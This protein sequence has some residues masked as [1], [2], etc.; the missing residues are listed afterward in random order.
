[1]IQNLIVLGDHNESIYR[2]IH[3]QESRRLYLTS[4]LCLVSTFL[5]SGC[6]DTG[7][8]ASNSQIPLSVN[9][10]GNGDTASIGTNSI[11]I[12]STSNKPNAIASASVVTGLAPLSTNLSAVDSFGGTGDLFYSWEFDDGAVA[13]G[14]TVSHTFEQPGLYEVLLQVTDADGETDTTILPIVVLPELQ[15]FVAGSGKGRTFFAQND[16]PLASLFGE[17]ALSWT[18]GDG[19]Q[20]QGDVVIHAY[21]SSGIFPVT[22]NIKIDNTQLQVGATEVAISSNGSSLIVAD[23][24]PDLVVA[25]GDFVTLDASN[26]TGPG[27]LAYQW[28][29]INDP[30]LSLTG[31]DTALLSFMAPEVSVSTMIYFQLTA[32]SGSLSEIDLV[33]V[34]VEPAGS[35]ITRTTPYYYNEACCASNTDELT[36]L[37]ASNSCKTIFLDSNTPYTFDSDIVIDRNVWITPLRGRNVTLSSTNGARILCSGSAGKTINFRLGT[38]GG[39]STGKTLYYN[40]ACQYTPGSKYATALAPNPN[41]PSDPNG[42]TKK[43]FFEAKGTYFI[44]LHRPGVVEKV[45]NYFVSQ[46]QAGGYDGICL[47]NVVLGDK[48]SLKDWADPVAY[49]NAVLALWDTIRAKVGPNV[50]M[51]VNQGVQLDPDDSWFDDITA[52]SRRNTVLM[53]ESINGP[54]NDPEETAV[55]NAIIATGQPCWWYAYANTVDEAVDKYLYYTNY[56]EDSNGLAYWSIDGGIRDTAA[57]IAASNAALGIPNSSIAMSFVYSVETDGEIDALARYYGSS[58][59]IWASQLLSANGSPTLL[60]LVNEWNEPANV[61]TIQT[62]SLDA[63]P[64]TPALVQISGDSGTVHFYGYNLLVQNELSDSGHGIEIDGGTYGAT[65]V[66]DQVEAVANGGGGIVATGSAEVTSYD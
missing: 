43:Y 4:L 50:L 63:D 33:T 2:Y 59:I 57:G 27:P 49:G 11:S 34:Q 54:Y 39:H 51:V 41:D 20:A 30:Q 35:T 62:D 15:I 19:G 3:M 66:L 10:S 9:Y 32:S 14:I 45:A 6:V 23:G 21:Q 56:L 44:A 58:K 52:P 31:M 37:L 65:A 47:D 38:P 8:A 1:M 7:S 48:S 13:S 36:S 22:L 42:L 12:Q 55:W 17:Y 61:L 25:S 5:T 28:L 46:Y 29:Q 53:F 60:Q 64:V 26:S 40:S 24:G 16:V 18:F